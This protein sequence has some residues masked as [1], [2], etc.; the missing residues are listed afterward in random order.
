MYTND[1]AADAVHDGVDAETATGEPDR[2]GGSLAPVDAASGTGSG[3]SKP[4]R[5]VVEALTDGAVVR[6]EAA[7]T[8][9]PDHPEDVS[10]P[11]HDNG[12]VVS[13]LERAGERQQFRFSGA[14]VDVEVAVG[15]VE[16]VL[17]LRGDDPIERERQARLSIH[18]QGSDVAY[19]FAVSGTVESRSG[20]AATEDGDDVATGTVS[21]SGVDEY[22]F[23][24]EVTEFE[25]STDD[26]LVLLN[27]RVVDPRELR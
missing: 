22:V 18:A 15:D 19:E 8:I 16:A 11:I 12:V 4:N 25:T 14:M 5:I 20:T 21:G 23:S 26:V 3:R 6:I 2:L 9:E 13:S 24:G 10:D 17:D 1:Q 27:D 7:G